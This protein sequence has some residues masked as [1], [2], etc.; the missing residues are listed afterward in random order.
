MPPEPKNPI[1]ELLET[2]A[3][4]RRAE[5]GADPKMP[6]PMPPPSPDGP[7]TKDFMSASKKTDRSLASDISLAAKEAKQSAPAA[8]SLAQNRQTTNFRQ[9]FSQKAADEAFRNK[10]KQPLNILN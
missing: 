9:Q 4:A 7:M 3:T 1:G 5:F 6:N 2:S 8:G 10:P